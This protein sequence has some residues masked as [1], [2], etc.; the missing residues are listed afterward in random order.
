MKTSKGSLIYSIFL[1]K[2]EE[3]ALA[4]IGISANFN[5][6]NL[7]RF[8]ECMMKDNLQFVFFF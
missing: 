1:R 7:L 8:F 3:E 5:E 6:A 2:L 4:R